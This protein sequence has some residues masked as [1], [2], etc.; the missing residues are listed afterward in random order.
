MIRIIKK[1]LKINKNLIK[2]IK[3]IFFRIKFYN[4]KP[5]AKILSKNYFN[6]RNI[7]IKDTITSI[8]QGNDIGQLLQNKKLIQYDERVVEYPYFVDWIIQGGIINEHLDIGC[9]ANT[10]LLD[11][12]YKK[13]FKSIYFSNVVIEP[14]KV[15]IP[16]YYHLSQLNNAFEDNRKFKSISCLSTIEHIGFD[17]SHY[18]SNIPVLYT[19][20]NIKPLLDSINDIARITADGGRFLIS[21]PYGYREVLIHPET[22]KGGSQTFSYNELSSA[23]ELLDQ[24]GFQANIEVYN[25]TNHGWELTDSKLCKAR[26][27]DGTPAA[28]A[29]AFLKGVKS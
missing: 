18:G 6:S 15:T 4:K 1:I 3:Y 5:I 28:S 27:A 26:Y 24:L 22:G 7:M 16:T 23:K 10:N 12:I 17:N 21:V 9:T 29:V 14:I 13:Y 2:Y 25:I 8:I 20:V 11:S 19:D